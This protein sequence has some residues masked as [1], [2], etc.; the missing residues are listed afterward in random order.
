MTDRL[1]IAAM[2]MANME[3]QQ[4]M[5]YEAVKTALSYAD[6]LLLA[7]SE[8][9]DNPTTPTGVREPIRCV[10]CGKLEVRYRQTLHEFTCH[11]CHAQS[12]SAA[13]KRATP[14]EVVGSSTV[15]SSPSAAPS[16]APEICYEC[17]LHDGRH[18]PTC[19]R[20]EAVFGVSS[21]VP[22]TTEEAVK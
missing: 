19:S 10:D 22:A 8:P 20:F 11:A 15:S 13:A 3:R 17:T 2:F 14:E 21:P 6:A 1:Q 5:Q 12:F 16:P 7:A 9:K 18:A 4:W